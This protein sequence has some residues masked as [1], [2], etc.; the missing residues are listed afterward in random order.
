MLAGIAGGDPGAFDQAEPG[1]K[2]G[3]KKGAARKKT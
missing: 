2:A 1:D 3:K